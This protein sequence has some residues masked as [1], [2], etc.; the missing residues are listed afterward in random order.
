MDD[1]RMAG[2]YE[3]LHALCIGEREVVLGY[4]PENKNGNYYMIAFCEENDLFSRYDNVIACPDYAEMV[5]LFAKRI[6]EQAHQV[7][8]QAEK[9]KREVTD[10]R[11]YDKW[12]CGTN[13]GC[14][15]V[16]HGDDLNGKVIVINPEI[17]RREYR[18]AT[19]QLQLCTGGF[20]AYPNSR[21][22]AVFCTN[23]FNGSKSRFERSDVLAV[24]DRS[25]LPEWV[26]KKL[27]ELQ[28][29]K[30]AHRGEEL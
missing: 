10:N 23:L 11:V 18:T 30:T 19:H 15:F 3:I 4:D 17:L 14:H 26:E 7:R 2:S 28:Q 9:E 16:S 12:R 27:N 21:G 29:H 25:V 1:K 5:E 8:E 24:M 13:P 6:A 20:G 22:S